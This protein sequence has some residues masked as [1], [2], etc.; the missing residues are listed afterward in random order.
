M[1]FVGVSLLLNCENLYGCGH[2]MGQQQH[3]ILAANPQVMR[4]TPAPRLTL[5]VA[6]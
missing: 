4:C 5:E 6:S 3:T 1:W 2:P